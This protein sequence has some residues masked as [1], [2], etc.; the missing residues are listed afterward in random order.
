MNFSLKIKKMF[1]NNYYDKIILWKYYVSDERW[2]HFLVSQ[3]IKKNS[4]KF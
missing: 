4:A 3:K 1:E 2:Y